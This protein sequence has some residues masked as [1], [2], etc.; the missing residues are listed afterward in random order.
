MQIINKN[1]P[2]QYQYITYRKNLKLMV[3]FSTF[4]TRFKN[5]GDRREPS[6]YPPLFILELRNYFNHFLVQIMGMIQ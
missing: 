2:I 3:A 5:T 4:R 6:L 1:Y